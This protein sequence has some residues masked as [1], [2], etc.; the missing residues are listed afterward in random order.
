MRKIIT[1]TFM[2]LV[3]IYGYSQNF[4][5]LAELLEIDGYYGNET[6][7]GKGGG[8]SFV[9]FTGDGFSDLT[10]CTEAGQNLLFFENKISHFE[11]LTN[12]FVVN[13]YETK[14]VYWIDIENDGDLDLFVTAYDNPNL[15]YINNGDL[16]FVESTVLYNLP[17]KFEKTYGANFSDINF[18]GYLDLYVSNWTNDLSSS[19]NEL[20]LFN[21]VT[22]FYDEISAYA[23]IMNDNNP[24]FCSSFFDFDFDGDLDFYIAND[25]FGPGTENQF[26]LNNGDL[27][28]TEVSNLNGSQLPTACSMSTTVADY[29][30][31]GF[32]DIYVTDFAGLPSHLLICL[33]TYTYLD[34]SVA[35]NCNTVSVYGWTA[36]FLDYD[37]DADQD[38]YVSAS[39]AIN[40][41]PN[42]FLE[43][44]GFSF[45]EP[46]AFS[47]GI[48]GSDTISSFANAIGDFNRDGKL[49]I[50]T[51][52]NTVQNFK[53]Y[54]NYEQNN[55]KF[56]KL[57]LVG[58]DSNIHAIGARVEVYNNGSKRLFQKHAG[59]GFLNQ[60]EDLIHIGFGST[61]DFDSLT[62]FWPYA[63]NFETFYNSPNVSKQIYT[64]TE[65]YGVTEVTPLGLCK[66]VHNVIMEP[67]P[68]QN[69]RSVN[70]TTS[71]SKVAF[72]HAV[73]FRSE[74]I[75]ELK[76]GFEVM[77]NSSFAA[78]IG[79]CE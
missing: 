8:M 25:C 71:A 70:L 51:S 63:N 49:D 38:L 74:N 27:T 41:F 5:D 4:N 7:A 17:I 67:I 9:D 72:N 55:N 29:N 19:T 22:G 45:N 43:N 79:D 52:G 2:A 20:Y 66:T 40:G 58:T 47:N 34:V 11:L 18:D 56:F 23:G 65:H 44:T 10:F 16:T 60:N 62:V 32:W 12:P 68:S 33:P 78:V 24:T 59:N 37:N 77:Q 73:T 57:K 76:S 54:V 21:A 35:T 61:F 64:L 30:N 28:F 6:G 36:N 39:N 48:G 42:P 46:F 26:Y 69:Y 13:L 31:N 14:Q 3:A 53:L 75:I 1:C 50:V 15:L